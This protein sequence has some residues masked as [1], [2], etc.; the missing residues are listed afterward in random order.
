MSSRPTALALN[1]S[2]EDQDPSS[3]IDEIEELSECDYELFEEAD[4]DTAEIPVPQESAIRLITNRKVQVTTNSIIAEAQ[5]W[6]SDK[7]RVK[8]EKIDFEVKYQIFRSKLFLH[9]ASR[10]FAPVY[11]PLT[12]GK[13]ADKTMI[14]N[15]RTKGITF[16]EQFKTKEFAKAVPKLMIETAQQ[17]LK[18]GNWKTINGIIQMSNKCRL[19][20]IHDIP[21]S[22]IKF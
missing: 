2:L 9:M 21:G 17:A 22:Q 16:L 1:T 8:L 19:A 20:L 4:F 11:T 18:D 5:E 10:F 13:K 14:K 3:Q 7:N 15:H 6:Y 12:H